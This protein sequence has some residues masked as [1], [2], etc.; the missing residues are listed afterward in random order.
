MAVGGVPAAVGGGPAFT[1]SAGHRRSSTAYLADVGAGRRPTR[2]IFTGGGRASI[3][4]PP[5]ATSNWP[6]SI[7]AGTVRRALS[8]VLIGEPARRGQGAGV[9][10]V[11]RAVCRSASLSSLGLH[12][13]DLVVFDFNAWGDRKAVK[14]P[15][16]AIE[17]DACGRPG[18]SARSSGRLV[19]MSILEHGV[20][21]PG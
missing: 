7:G 5:S 21:G 15:A 20:G 14:E 3:E 1:L 9:E 13:I 4:R 10:M 11:R 12:R 18:G 19:Q 6:G 16:F 8:R 2:M 17:R